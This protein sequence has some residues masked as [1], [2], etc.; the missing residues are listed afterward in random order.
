MVPMTMPSRA[1]AGLRSSSH[2]L[3]CAALE[4]ERPPADVLERLAHGAAVRELA[5]VAG[6]QLVHQAGHAHTE[7]LV[8][9]RREDRAEPHAL[10]QRH[11]VVGCQLEHPS[12]EV[13]PRQL[14]IEE[15]VGLP[16]ELDLRQGYFDTASSL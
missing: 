13:E 14:A 7:E 11:V 1:R 9:V 8:E 2:S 10:E 3:A 5:R 4:L 15:A 16:G 6:V 12:V